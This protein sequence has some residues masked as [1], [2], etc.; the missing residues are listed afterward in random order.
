MNCLD[1]GNDFKKISDEY[2][3]HL[4][5]EAARQADTAKIK[6]Y[7]TP[8]IINFKHPYTGDTALHAA[9]N[10]L[11][12]KRKQVIETL[13]R[14]G[15]HLNEKNKDFLTPL[16]IASDNSNY[17]L[18]DLLL[19]HSAKVNALDGLGQTALH[20]CAREDNV[21]ACRILLSY[22]V[23]LSIVSLQGYTAAQV[24][25]E[26][27]LKILQGNDLFIFLILINEI[28]I[29][30]CFFRSSDWYRRRRVSNPGGRQ[31]RRSRPGSKTAGIIPPYS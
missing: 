10:S 27:V 16:H 3:G 18:M 17:D 30:K 4:L 25:S 19:R 7:L 5:L 31:V 23:D 26:N 8:E 1:I 11:Y 15:I 28:G 14:K 21:Q 29:K 20:R 12:P 9:V 13:I 6:K 24:A 2:K 22:S